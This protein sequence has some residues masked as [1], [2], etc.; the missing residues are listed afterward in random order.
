MNS[1]WFRQNKL[2]VTLTAVFVVVLG[3]EIWLLWKHYTAHK[4]VDAGLAAE[5]QQLQALQ[6][7]T[8]TPN[9]SNVAVAGKNH[10]LLAKFN[11]E[12]DSRLASITKPTANIKNNILFAQ[13]LRK[14]IARLEDRVKAAKI[15]TPNNWR[16]G[17][18]RYTTNVPDKG[19]PNV[20]LAI[21]EQLNVVKKLTDLMIESR[22]EQIY[23]MKRVEIEPLPPGVGR[24][25][26]T[27]APEAIKFP[28]GKDYI[29]FPFELDFACR[30]SVLQGVLNRIATS[31]KFFAIQFLT[32]KQ[33]VV[34]K[35]PDEI[36]ATDA[37]AAPKEEDDE[38]D[39]KKTTTTPEWE[40]R[41][42]VNMR[43]AFIMKSSDEKTDG[44]LNE[45]GLVL[46][47]NGQL[48]AKEKEPKR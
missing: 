48:R 28:S 4:Q 13:H 31:D 29:S 19:L 3:C 35:Q 23:A 12:L 36:A 46:G 6:N 26:E 9:D 34:R 43:L 39:H 11:G 42:R 15:S 10:E 16:F 44:L 45:M 40:P 38:D 33:E 25:G 37:A 24:G 2:L 8:P 18:R 22:V 47:D 41:L 30:A 7:Y 32:I 27:L 1:H 20:I 14:D 5:M 17:F 21:G